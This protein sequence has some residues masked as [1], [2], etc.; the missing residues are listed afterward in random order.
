ME[1]PHVSTSAK[2]GRL[3]S[4]PVRDTDHEVEHTYSLLVVGV[5]F[6]ETCEEDAAGALASLIAASLTGC[7]PA[8][9]TS[10]PSL[11]YPPRR[12]P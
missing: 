9:A 1:P 12:N 6:A 2:R 8:A 10:A 3:P 7:C 5:L 11:P 4:E